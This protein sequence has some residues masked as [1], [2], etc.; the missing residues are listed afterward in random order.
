M[1]RADKT[2]SW[3]LDDHGVLYSIYLFVY[4]PE[5]MMSHVGLIGPKR[6]DP[7]AAVDQLRSQNTTWH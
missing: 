6:N 5:R 1:K 3:T 7:I 2:Y 4:S